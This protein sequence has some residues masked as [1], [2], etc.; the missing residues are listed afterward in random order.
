[1]REEEQTT[2]GRRQIITLNL[3]ASKSNQKKKNC[4]E[5]FIEINRDIIDLY[6]ETIEILSKYHR[7]LLLQI[8]IEKLSNLIEWPYFFKLHISIY[9]LSKCIA[10]L[11]KYHRVLLM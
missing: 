10:L 4:I 1:M 9:I 3:K 8:S 6:R 11:S 2:N 5:K 7:I